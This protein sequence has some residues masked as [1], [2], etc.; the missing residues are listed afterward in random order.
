MKRAL[1]RHH[2]ERMKRKAYRIY[3]EIWSAGSYSTCSINWINKFV[4]KS[5]DNMAMC[6]CDMCGNP[7]RHPNSTKERLTFQERKE[8][9]KWKLLEL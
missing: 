1:R 9:E 7:R 4:N 3:T 6:S 5:A 2:K 8:L